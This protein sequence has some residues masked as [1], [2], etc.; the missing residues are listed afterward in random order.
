M[1]NSSEIVIQI[2]LLS[3]ILIFCFVALLFYIMIKHKHNSLLNENQIIHLKH[4][5][6]KDILSAQ[7]E[8]QEETM[9]RI[10]REIHDNISLG[11]TLSKL[12]LNSSLDIQDEKI[13]KNIDSSIDLIS[14]SLV[15]LNDLSKSINGETIKKIG[16]IHSIELDIEY[17][18]RINLFKIDFQIEGHALYLDWTK[19][20]MIFRIIQESF[21]NII[22]HSLCSTILIKLTFSEKELIVEI[23]DDGIGF[24]FDYDNFLNSES[25]SS[26]LANMHNRSLL[27]NAKFN[28]CSEKN[29]GT[30]IILTIPYL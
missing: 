9:I 12:Y 27:I 7:L 15:D 19:E 20:I 8:M 13:K 17:L 3:T 30:K 11:L 26:G 4:Q 16:L 29:M 18:K 10:S 5:F 25:R 2:A 6:E 21:R 1:E 22:K 24:D 28:V 23:K 14:K